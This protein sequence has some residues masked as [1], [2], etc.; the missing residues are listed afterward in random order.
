MWRFSFGLKKTFC[1][2]VGKK[3]FK[4]EPYWYICGQRIKNVDSLDVLGSRLSN[5]LR[6]AEHVENRISKCRRA[7]FGLSGAGMRYPGLSTAA[8]S[9]LWKTIGLPSLVFGAEAQYIAV[10]D[11]KR[12]ESAQGCIVKGLNGLGK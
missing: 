1:M 8:K 11:M 2:T 6:S 7:I 5:D 10:G 9:Y 12:M 4:Q 3:P